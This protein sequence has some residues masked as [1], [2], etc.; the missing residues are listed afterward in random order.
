MSA[1]WAQ[2]C[3]ALVTP[4]AGANNVPVNQ[5]ISWNPVAGVPG[6]Q[7]RIGTTPGGSEI[8]QASIGAATSYTPPLGLPD[9]T[10]IYVT[11]ILD[12]LFQGGEDIV[13]DSQ[14]FRTE[15]ITTPPN[16][17]IVSNLADGDIN[18]NVATN[19]SWSYVVGATGYRVTIGTTPGGTQLVNN[20]DVGNVLNYFPPNDLDPDTTYYVIV[21]AYNENGTATNCIEI[22]FTTGQQ[23]P[24]PSCTQLIGFPQNGDINVP[25]TPF[26]QWN[27]VPGATG[28]RVT[29]GST[30][31]GEDILDNAVFATNSTF[32]LDFPPNQTYF[33]SIIPFNTSGDAVGC[34]QESF[35]TLIGC[36]PYLDPTTGEFIDFSPDL[37]FNSVYSFCQG[38]GSFVLEAP[39]GAD[40]Y[41]WYQVNQFGAD[42]LISNQQEVLISLQGNYIL[43]AYNLIQNP[44]DATDFIECPQSYPF[45]VTTSEAARIDNLIIEDT[46]LGLN[47]TVEVSGIGDYEF[48][49]DEENGPYQTSNTFIAVAPGT[50]TI[51]V[52]DRNG[53]GVVSET[54]EQDITVEGFPKF[55]TPNG[56]GNNDFWQ[57]RQSQV[58]DPIFLPIIE[59]YD[60]YGK[61]LFQFNSQSEG[62]DGTYNGRQVIAGNYWFRA[63]SDSGQVL[64]GYFV[65]K[66]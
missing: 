56:D 16:C 22:S 11:I 13:C 1:I 52:R 30:P 61:L 4:A 17:A 44:N 58:G 29:I 6:Y 40:G 41:R 42:F 49:I 7:I 64:N 46:A 28:Y 57:F 25:L 26:L 21:V 5:T 50:H 62:W 15:N 14:S 47:I 65:L 31:G 53:C 39:P 10:L 43:E 48:A 2:G 3:P 60:R 20:L 36:G 55:F 24:I 35:S 27:A 33:I 59:V 63:Q 45:E 38:D 32:V 51:Y 66:R 9:N 12:F 54:F 8:V 18:V 19:I 23:E 37:D 34:N